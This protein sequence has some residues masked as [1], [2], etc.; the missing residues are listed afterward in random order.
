MRKSNTQKLGEIIGEYL[1]QMMIDRKLKEYSIIRSW[2]E[3]MGRLV[4]ERTSNIYVKNKV[5]F[6][7]LKSSVLRNELMMMRHA[8]I[9][10]INEKAGEKIIEKIVVK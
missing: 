2:E 10:K 7:E 3:L 8:I 9:D 5:L 1:K 6:I 4:A